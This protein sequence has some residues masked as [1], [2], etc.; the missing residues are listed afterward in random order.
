MLSEHV[1]NMEFTDAFCTKQPR[2]QCLI[3]LHHYLAPLLAWHVLDPISNL[4]FISCPVL[5][6]LHDRLCAT[7][8]VRDFLATKHMTGAGWELILGEYHLGGNN[9]SF[10]ALQ[11]YCFGIKIKL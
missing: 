10:D 1:V 5:N 7:I 9:Y 11:A 8:V 6:L 3:Y 4:A 2:T